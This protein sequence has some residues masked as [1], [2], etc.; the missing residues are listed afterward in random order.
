MLTEKIKKMLE[1]NYMGQTT[2]YLESL[3]CDIAF[4]R[5]FALQKG[6]S[7]LET[8]Y[9]EIEEL[10]LSEITTRNKGRFL[11]VFNEIFAD[12]DVKR[13]WNKDVEAL[14]ECLNGGKSNVK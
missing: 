10:I 2:T 5:L 6:E 12:E 11:K 8:L 1:E 3:Y 4:A 7:Q 14:H 9:E 13:Y